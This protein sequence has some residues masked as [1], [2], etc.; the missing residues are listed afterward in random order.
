LAGGRRA[1]LSIQGPRT[2]YRTTRAGAARPATSPRRAI[3]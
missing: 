1:P 2:S 3:R